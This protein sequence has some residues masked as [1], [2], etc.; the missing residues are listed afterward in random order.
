[1]ETINGLQKDLGS[2]FDFAME[3]IDDTRKIVSEGLNDV[4]EFIKPEEEK[5]CGRGCPGCNK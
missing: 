4:A 2:L 1:M 3:L 5:K